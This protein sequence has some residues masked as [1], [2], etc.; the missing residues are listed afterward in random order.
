MAPQPA[1]REAGSGAGLRRYERHRP[2]HTLLYELVEEHYPAFAQQMAASPGGE[3]VT[4][5]ISVKAH[6][7]PRIRF[8][9]S[10]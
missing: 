9:V 4:R 10:L 1:G 3:S 5:R 6:A 2:E 8:G 7:V